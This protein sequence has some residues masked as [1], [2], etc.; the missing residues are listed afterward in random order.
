MSKRTR[1]RPAPHGAA[2]REQPPANSAAG[3]RTTRRPLRR[4][5]LGAALAAAAIVAVAIYAS[6]Q[7]ASQPVI[8]SGAGAQA[9]APDG[10]FT[11]LSGAPGS[12]AALRG[13][14]TLLWFVTTWCSSC[15]AG[16]QAMQAQIPKLAARHV[17]LVELE[18][19]GDLGQPG[20]SMSEFADQ[21]AGGFIHDPVWTF[22]TASPTLTRT[23]DPNGYLDIYY[24]LTP[25]GRVAYINSSP[26]AT[27]PQLLS[28]VDK[29]TRHA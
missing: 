22:G 1:T 17:R 8:A 16:T 2:G 12:V 11:A 15:Q 24:L 28:A 6:S 14:T 5:A 27:M 21:L 25:N 3:T 7:G 10:S 23:Y 13:H 4:W 26:A 19:S 29:I 9:S 18:L 20:P